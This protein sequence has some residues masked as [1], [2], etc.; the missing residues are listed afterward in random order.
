MTCAVF[1]FVDWFVDEATA[2]DARELV[3]A[4]APALPPTAA[5]IPPSAGACTIFRAPDA[6]EWLVVVISASLWKGREM[7]IR[8]D[9]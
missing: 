1:N 6:A 4:P 2:G 3:A 5:A 9:S 7:E 8:S